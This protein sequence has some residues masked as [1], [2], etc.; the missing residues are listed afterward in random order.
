[1]KRAGD[2]QTVIDGMRRLAADPNL[3]EPQFIP[4]PTTWL[5]RNGWEDDPLP[6]RT[7]SP[8]ESRTFGTR[9]EDWL[10]EPPPEAPWDY[11]DGEVLE[12]KE[13]T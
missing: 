11:V 13:L 5:E 6:S 4:H 2:E 1:M 12:T 8:Q 3:P 7:P 9:P 10:R